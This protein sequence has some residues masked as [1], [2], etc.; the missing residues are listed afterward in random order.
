MAD[1]GLGSEGVAG[2]RLRGNT[3]SE[4]SARGLPARRQRRG[5]HRTR[6]SSPSRGGLDSWLTRLRDSACPYLLGRR[7]NLQGFVPLGAADEAKSDRCDLHS[8]AECRMR[9][10]PADRSQHAREIAVRAC[11]DPSIDPSDPG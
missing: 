8:H 10:L 4:L 5:A 11:L 2:T 7:D 1:H 3:G 6:A 9:A